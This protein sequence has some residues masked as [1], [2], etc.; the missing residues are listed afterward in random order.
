MGYG[1]RRGI[2]DANDKALPNAEMI[3]AMI[4]NPAA[5]RNLNYLAAWR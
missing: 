3:A 5:F 1:G 4:Y 2:L